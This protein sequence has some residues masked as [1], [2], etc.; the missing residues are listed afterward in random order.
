MTLRSFGDFLVLLSAAIGLASSATAAPATMRIDTPGSTF[1]VV[2]GRATADNAPDGLHVR[3]GASTDVTVQGVLVLPPDEMAERRASRLLLH[4]R[5]SPGGPTLRTIVLPDGQRVD[6]NLEGDFLTESKRNTID[7]GNIPMKLYDRSIVKLVISFPGGFEGNPNPGEF[8]LKSVSV[9][10]PRKAD[11]RA[12]ESARALPPAALDKNRARVETSRSVAAAHAIFEKPSIN[13]GAGLTKRLDLC[14]V[15][16]SECGQSAANAFCAL[17]GYSRATRYSPDHDI[18]ETAIIS[19]HQ[20]C[21]N[22]A[23]DGFARIECE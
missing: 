20:I 2:Q 13:I 21:N 8:V 9:D 12:A 15:W 17:Q 10:A 6:L 5:T 22:P 16:G 19:S 18:G 7:F 14:R 23:C 11:V 4:F 3:G 1:R